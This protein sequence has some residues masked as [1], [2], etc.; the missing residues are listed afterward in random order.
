MESLARMNP[1]LIEALCKGLNK[2]KKVK[3]ILEGLEEMRQ[4]LLR[5]RRSRAL[6]GEQARRV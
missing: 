2:N 1:Q 5:D 6:S 3:D 4:E